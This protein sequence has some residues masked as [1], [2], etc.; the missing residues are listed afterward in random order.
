MTGPTFP[1]IRWHVERENAIHSAIALDGSA[2]GGALRAW[3]ATYRRSGVVWWLCERAR[4]SRAPAGITGIRC[5]C[6]RTS[7]ELVPDD[8]DYLGYYWSNQQ[9]P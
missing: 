2:T 1:V 8:D 7:T 9:D 3:L 4:C 5:P 6:G